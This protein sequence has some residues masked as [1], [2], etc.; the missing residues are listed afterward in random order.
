MIREAEEE[1][2][3]GA[4]M[5]REKVRD[6]GQVKYFGLSDR[7][8]E[9]GVGKEG[10]HQPECG[11]VFEIELDEWMVPKPRDGKVEDVYSWT[12]DEVSE[13]L[14]KAEFKTNSAGVMVDCLRWHEMLGR[15]VK[16]KFMVRLRGERGESLNF[17]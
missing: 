7:R 9:K 15:V 4:G 17:H 10:S 3:L 11:L 8:K 5:V 1:A 2:S 6:C 12:V 16:A 13:A 14:G